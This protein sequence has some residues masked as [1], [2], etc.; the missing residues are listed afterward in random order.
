MNCLEELR[1]VLTIHGAQ[2]AVKAGTT[3][4]QQLYA[5]NYSILVMV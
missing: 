5:D 4:M 3:K 2:C 1:C